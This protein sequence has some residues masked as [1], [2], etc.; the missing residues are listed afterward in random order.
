MDSEKQERE[1]T[2][3][4][5]SVKDGSQQAFKD[6]LR[7][8]DLAGRQTLTV[9]DNRELDAIA[10][11]LHAL[12]VSRIDTGYDES[13]ERE[14]RERCASR[15]AGLG[16]IVKRLRDTGNPDDL[17]DGAFLLGALDEISSYVDFLR[18]ALNTSGPS[19]PLPTSLDVACSDTGGGV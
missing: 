19:G 6:C 9:G 2:P 13:V 8:R 10:D 7:L 15:V 3:G 14:L 18:E 1:A 17:A 16:M 5:A 11:R 4:V 12:A